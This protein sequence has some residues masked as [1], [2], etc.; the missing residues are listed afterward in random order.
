MFKRII[1]YFVIVCFAAIITGCLKDNVTPSFSFQS[2]NSVDMVVYF[3]THGDIINSTDVPWL[4][5][6]KTINGN[7]AGY[8]LID[9]RSEDEFSKGHIP[10]AKNLKVRDLLNFVKNLDPQEHSKI[11]LISATGQ[12]SAYYT[13]LLRFAGINNVYSLKYGMASWNSKFAKLWL[14]SCKDAPNINAYTNN[15]GK[16][17]SPGILPSIT[18]AINSTDIKIKIESRIN[19]LLLKEFSDSSSSI[20][21]DQSD[22]PSIAYN[23]VFSSELVNE[24]YIVCYGSDDLYLE[25][26]IFS[27][28][29]GRGHPKGT[30]L[31]SSYGSLNTYSF[32]NTLPVNKKII[33]Y[34]IDGQASAAAAAYLRILGYDAK[35]LLFGA[36]VLFYGRLTTNG[37]F[38]DH[39]FES[40]SIMEYNFE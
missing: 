37:T 34:S 24:Y 36:H 2:E 20:S 6:A 25:T 15:P 23:N 8:L 5:D 18:F 1:K 7:P 38:K 27:A 31:Y 19:E 13:S 28:Y 32:L 39:I 22:G 17:N 9:T 30:V 33:L 12:A 29:K 10:N 11:V 40:S 21:T 4:I 26:N 3:E 35:S 16:M 14:S